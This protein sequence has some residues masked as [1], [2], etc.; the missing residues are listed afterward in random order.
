MKIFLVRHGEVD[1]NLLRLYNLVD[2]SLNETGIRQ[3]DELK[4]KVENLNYDIIISSPLLRTIQTA[5][6]INAKKK[7]IMLDSRLR[8]REPGSL[9]GK[10]LDSVDRED[11]WDYFS[12]NQYGA[13][14]VPSLFLRVYS[15]L[16]ELRSKSYNSV[17]IVAHSGVSKAFHGY[18]YGLQD[19][20]FLYRGLKNC[21]II[22]YQ[23]P[24]K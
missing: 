21:E 19:G 13:E 23:F 15:F 22:E 24:Q 17:L 9:S 12:K 16:D 10:P 1:D 8:E 14:S 2:D 4:S 18:F 3:A 20:K 11:Y 6:L 5:S 7:K